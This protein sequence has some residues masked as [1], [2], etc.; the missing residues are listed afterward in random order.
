MRGQVCFVRVAYF[1]ANTVAGGIRPGHG[2]FCLWNH[3]VGLEVN[4]VMESTEPD[5]A[6]TQLPFVL[7]P[8]E[9]RV[10]G[11]LLEKEMATPEYYP[12]TLNALTNACN[13]K[14]NRKPMMELSTEEVREALDALREKKLAM[15]VSV[16]DSRVP[17]FKRV[18]EL[19]DDPGPAERAVL[20]ELLVRGPQTAGELRT[21]CDRLRPFAGVD[22]VEKVLRSLAEASPGALVRKLSRRPGHK[23][24]RY[25]QLLTGEPAP[26]EGL[27]GEDGPEPQS[28]TGGPLSRR[29]DGLEKEVETLR[30][31]VRELRAVFEEFRR[32][33]E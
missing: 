15:I 7:S 10:L 14:S 5:P 3:P 12:M 20:C 32:Q 21:R 33:F 11:C 13:Q 9:A 23:E 1:T 6:S 25:A 24:C 28:G 8:E 30:A 19:L 22:E 18:T 27:A 26:E 17:K 31:E 4:G 29:V 2:V 16:A